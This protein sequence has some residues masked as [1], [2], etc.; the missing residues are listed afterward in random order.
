MMMSPHIL[1]LFHWLNFVI[2]NLNKVCC[3]NDTA[4]YYVTTAAGNTATLH[5][6]NLLK[7]TMAHMMPQ[8]LSILLSLLWY[9]CCYGVRQ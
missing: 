9:L 5:V 4:G 3:L 8:V 7:D 1:L 2:I 6:L